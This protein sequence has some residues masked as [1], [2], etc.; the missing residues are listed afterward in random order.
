M[1][2]TVKQLLI[3][4]TPIACLIFTACKK[5]N[6][7][8]ESITTATQENQESAG[9]TVRGPLSKILGLNDI[10][11]TNKV[12]HLALGS[13]VSAGSF[14]AETPAYGLGA[15]NNNII[16]SA[17][18]TSNLNYNGA[19]VSELHSGS[20]SGP[21]FQP[22]ELEMTGEYTGTLLE[23]VVYALK[24]NAIYKINDV[25]GGSSGYSYATVCYSFPSSWASYRKTICQGPNMN[26]LRV[27]VAATGSAAGASVSSLQV[28]NLY[29][30]TC[31]LTG[32]VSVPIAYDN[33][34]DLASFSTRQAGELSNWYH[35]VISNPA[36]N[37]STIYRLDGTTTLTGTYSTVG[38]FPGFVRDCAVN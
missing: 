37:T 25:F 10:L 36:T 27:I 2:K 7:N 3:L 28:Y 13:Y 35:I 34:K 22:E 26:N 33:K 38:N 4:G 1:R 32:L 18:S 9:T 31:E 24:G 5:N 14:P 6:V 15:H 21:V 23:P 20:A 29:L 30:P 11:A 19:F 8:E 16:Y 17:Y 12:Y